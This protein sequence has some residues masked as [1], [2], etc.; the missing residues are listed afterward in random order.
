VYYLFN[1]NLVEV[2][3]PDVLKP[4][5]ML[6]T[7]AICNFTNGLKSWLTGTITDCPEEIMLNKVLVV[8]AL[9]H[10]LR[11][12]IL[13]N[14]LDQAALAVLQKSSKIDRMFD[15]LNPVEF[16]TIQEQASSVCQCDDSM[17]H[18]LEVHFKKTISAKL[19]RS[20]GSLAVSCRYTGAGTV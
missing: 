6:L 2:L 10:I 12:Y 14:R 15:D 18:Q 19:I 13:L 3:I 17:V 11:C 5:P 9:A 4:V 16:C 1:Q 7:R 8:S 20:I